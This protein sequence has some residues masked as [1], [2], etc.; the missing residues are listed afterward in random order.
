MKGVI[1][2]SLESLVDEKFG[3]QKWQEILE[4][5]GLSR[6]SFFLAI[7]DVD[8]TAVMKVIQTA[9][10]LLGISQSELADEFG[11]YWVN[12]YAPRYY[13]VYYLGA[14]SARE[15]LLKMSDV[16][17]NV[18]KSMP[19]AHPPRF[20][21]VP[22]SDNKLIMKYFSERGLMDFMVGLI[23]GVGHY[24]KE[25]LTVRQLTDNEVEISFE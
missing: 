7:D 2:N 12:T 13:K 22:V 8:D 25:N 16:H 9:C 21:Y 17:R 3:H 1:V 19:N 10:D 24:Y 5:A 23:K 6:D 4:K 14:K 18:T 20:E 15:F 11:D